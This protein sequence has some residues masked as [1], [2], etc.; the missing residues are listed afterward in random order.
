MFVINEKKL[1]DK[2]LF[3]LLKRNDEKTKTLVVDM[4]YEKLYRYFI[5]QG[6]KAAEAEELTQETFYRFF[7][8]IK[9]GGAIINFASYL[10]KV[11]K[12]LVVDNVRFRKKNETLRKRFIC[13]S[14]NSTPKKDCDKAIGNSLL[15]ELLNVLNP[16]ER[17]T[18]IFHIVLGYT[19]E[20]MQALLGISL[21]KV[22]R[23]FYKAI[24][25]LRILY[26]KHSV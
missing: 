11:A 15:I 16:Q 26:F 9:A 4:Y 1:D 8:K 25:K 24:E 6:F 18:V 17:D 19:F 2:E 22:K 14:E 5:L 10:F 3:Q 23:I 12:N 21:A 7:Y 13:A 20:E